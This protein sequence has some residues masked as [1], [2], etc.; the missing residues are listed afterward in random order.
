MRVEKPD[1]DMGFNILGLLTLQERRASMSRLGYACRS[2]RH[3]RENISDPVTRHV[4][5][6]K[7]TLCEKGQDPFGGFLCGNYEPLHMKNHNDKRLAARQKEMTK[8]ANAYF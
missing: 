2:C 6:A 7:E 5:A 4:L 1:R 3:F 8:A